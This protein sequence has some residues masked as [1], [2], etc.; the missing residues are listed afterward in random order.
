MAVQAF[1]TFS[2]N[3]RRVMEK[4]GLSQREIAE[5]AGTKHPNVNRILS[6]KQVPTL[7]LADR[8]ADAAGVPLSELLRAS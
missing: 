6:G 1:S 7:E 8:L 4:R 3:L 5:R 2:R